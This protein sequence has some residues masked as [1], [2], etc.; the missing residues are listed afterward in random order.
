MNTTPIRPSYIATRNTEPIIIDGLLSEQQW[1]RDG[2]TNFTQRDPVEGA[3]PTQ[4]TELWI[5]YDDNALYV[6][7]RLYDS[8]P[9]SIVARVGR[10]DSDLNS[11]WFFLAIDSYLDRRNGFFFGVNPS[12]SI[13]D[14]IIYNDEALDDSWDAVWDAEARI[15]EQGWTVEMRIPY[16]Q[17]RFEKKDEY[18]WGFNCLRIIE[19]YK[20]EDYLVYIPKNES[21]FVSRFADLIE[22]RDIQMFQMVQPYS[23]P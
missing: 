20:E 9:D 23:E 5:S 15:D 22:I 1:K 6:A 17:L 21:G 18:I 8:A 12:G 10:R 16:S 11:D 2:I 14:G 13:K 3:Q 4:R 19:R 7:V